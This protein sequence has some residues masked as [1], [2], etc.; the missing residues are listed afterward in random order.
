MD[1]QKLEELVEEG[2]TQRE[3][4]SRFGLSQTSIVYWLKKTNLVTKPARPGC[5]KHGITPCALCKRGSSAQVTARRKR[6]KQELV[7]AKGGRC[8]HPTCPVDPGYDFDQ[9]DLDFHHLDRTIKSRNLS[10]WSLS[11]A[12]AQKEAAKCILVCALCHRRVEREYR[13]TPHSE[14]DITKAS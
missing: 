7:D 6:I 10:N 11:F 4:A 5:R 14:M 12:E 8:E 13:S 9:G 2:L 1:T 3:I